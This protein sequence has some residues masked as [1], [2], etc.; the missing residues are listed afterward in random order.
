[1][2][3][4]AII[5]HVEAPSLHVMSYNIRRRL[6]HLNPMSPD[7]WERRRRFLKRQL[8]VEQP[9]ILGVQEA[10]P[11]QAT[12][13]LAA[14][15]PDYRFVGH[16]RETDGSG[17]GCPLFFDRARLE[18]L[19][20]KQTALS[21]TP[22]MPGSMSWGNRIPRIA[23]SAV[24]R[25]RETTREISVINTHFDHLFHVSR[26]RSAAAVRD[27]VLASPHPALVMGDFNT[28]AATAPHD[29]LV[30]GDRLN[31]SWMVGKRISESW[32]T[33]PNYRDPQ[34]GRKRIDWILVSPSVEV[35]ISAINTTR[36]DGAWASDHTPVQAVVRVR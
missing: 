10:L 13:V 12:F 36:F 6:P 34:H 2:T 5:G 4:D 18:L 33:F 27:L 32:G 19:Q 22:N 31:D 9:S 23:V 1:M 29:A 25:D 7:R 24:F 17:E 20:W 26:S 35:L 28:D 3:D 8:A 16:G 14:L 15:G 11:D 21:D 30:A